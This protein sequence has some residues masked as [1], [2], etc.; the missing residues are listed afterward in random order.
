MKLKVDINRWRS[1]ATTQVI[2]C[3]P[4]YAGSMYVHKLFVS[5]NIYD[6]ESLR[7]S[8]TVGGQVIVT[9]VPL[10]KVVEEGGGIT[11]YEALIPSKLFDRAQTVA[12]NIGL[13]TVS[14]GVLS[15]ILVTA[16]VTFDIQGNGSV[17]E[18]QMS[19]EERAVYDGNL[20]LLTGIVNDT[21]EKVDGISVGTVKTVTGLPGAAAK[22]SAKM[23][24]ED[25][26]LKLDFEFELPEGKVGGQG[27]SGSDGTDGQNGASAYEIWLSNGHTGT[28]AEF[29][30]WL[31]GQDGKDGQ[32]GAQGGGFYLCDTE[33]VTTQ[34]TIERSHLLSDS[35]I[36][37]GDTIVDVKG[38][39]FKVTENAAADSNVKIAYKK[40]SFRGPIGETPNITFYTATNGNTVGVPQVLA[41]QSGTAKNP[42]LTLTFLNLKGE[43]GNDG[44]DG[45]DGKDGAKGAD[46]KSAY[47]QAKEVGYTGTE[48]EFKLLLA[49]L[50]KFVLDGTTLKI[51]LPQ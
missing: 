31:K 34:T 25:G 2:D 5:A 37:E 23:K 1:A 6:N 28:E 51:T 21:K 15:Q 27:A 45:E 35:A 38:N 29:L 43:K 47:Q 41:E 22:A 7:A 33:V 20:A 8:F 9:N 10:T 50:P 17:F 40:A 24:T 16:P 48:A 3:E 13:F 26:A 42:I 30:T 4:M 14:N 18:N 36:L 19:E 39:L 46:G 12:V 44:N 11:L 32:D 49:G